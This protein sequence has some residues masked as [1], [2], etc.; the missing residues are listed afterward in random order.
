MIKR[1]DIL[2]SRSLDGEYL[3]KTAEEFN[4]TYYS[5]LDIRIYANNILLDEILSLQWQLQEAFRPN[6]NYADYTYRSQ[7]HGVRTVQGSLSINFTR[8]DYLYSLLSQ[9]ADER[10]PANDR[11]TNFRRSEAFRM[12]R[13]G[14]ATL[15]HFV[16]AAGGGNL[17]LGSAGKVRVDPRILQQTAEDF[18]NAIWGIN[19]AV[20]NRGRE[21][22]LPQSRFIDLNGP[23]FEL[24]VP[25]HINIQYGSVP[26]ALDARRQ[27]PGQAGATT[28][29][30][31]QISIGTSRR[32]IGVDLTQS[33]AEIDDSGRPVAEVYTF[34]ARD[35]I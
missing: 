21:P 12:A 20:T 30:L 9:L 32:I 35:V 17:R 11:F 2:N 1:R 16:A 7:A 23:R 33:M 26:E 10:S 15:E 22:K 34:S 28:R 13:T 3:W 14:T 18:E 27:Q 29:P 24:P 25:F 4:S 19:E 5:G 31:E 6:F 8:V